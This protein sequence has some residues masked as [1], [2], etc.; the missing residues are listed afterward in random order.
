MYVYDA[1]RTARPL[2][3]LLLLLVPLLGTIRRLAPAAAGA[4]WL[5]CCHR[6]VCYT[7]LLRLL[8]CRF[9]E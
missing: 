4:A 8:R 7:L 2:L 3:L 6:T 9:S 5:S 1:V